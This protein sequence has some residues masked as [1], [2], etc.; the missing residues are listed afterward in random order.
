[1]ASGFRLTWLEEATVVLTVLRLAGMTKVT[2][3]SSGGGDG[4]VG[5]RRGWGVAAAHPLPYIYPLTLHIRP[6]TGP[7][8]SHAAD[9][10]HALDPMTHAN[11]IHR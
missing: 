6:P 7:H 5:V 11:P 4:K 2:D 9:T 1:M 8:V 3:E 10:F